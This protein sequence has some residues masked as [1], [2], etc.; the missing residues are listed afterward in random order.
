[1]TRDEF[2]NLDWSDSHICYDIQV[3]QYR[4]ITY[5]TV[6]KYFPNKLCLI[7]DNKD[8]PVLNSGCGYSTN[9]KPYDILQILKYHK[10]INGIIVFLDGCI[11]DLIPKFYVNGIDGEILFDTEF[12]KKYNKQEMEKK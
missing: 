4:T 9:P 3:G 10:E 5:F 2:I 1:M 7:A 11:Y 6:S 12:I 8:F